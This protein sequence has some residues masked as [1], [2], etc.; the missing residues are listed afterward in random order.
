M[1]SPS[2]D[3]RD[4]SPSNYA[5]GVV[6]VEVQTTAGPYPAEGHLRV[7]ATEKIAV[8][9]SRAAEALGLIDTANWIAT[10]NNRAVATSSTYLELSLHGRLRIDWGPNHGGGG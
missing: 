7:S 4:E 5:G 1:S 2:D 9:L 8:I 10:I 6:N 3:K